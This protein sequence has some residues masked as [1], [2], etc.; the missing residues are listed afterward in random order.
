VTQL[1]YDGLVIVYL[2]SSSRDLVK[3]LLE[4]MEQTGADFTNTFR[5]L[6]RLSLPSSARP[7]SEEIAGVKEYLLQQCASLD[8]FKLAYAPKIDPR[9]VC[10][11]YAL[12]ARSTSNE[13]N[14]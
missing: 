11:L 7:N 3:S 8:D 13:A 6:S 12:E 1:A 5:C 10:L 9:F 2:F 4:T 14:C